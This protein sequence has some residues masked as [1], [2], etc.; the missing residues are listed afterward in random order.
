V[1]ET[2]IFVAKY[3]GSDGHHIWSTRFGDVSNDAGNAVAVDATGNV[4]VTGSFSGI[5]NFGGGSLT[6]SAATADIFL[7]KFSSSGNHVWSKRFGVRSAMLARH[8]D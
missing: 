3:A 8:C 6:S 1:R 5:V 7:A 4:V 2:D